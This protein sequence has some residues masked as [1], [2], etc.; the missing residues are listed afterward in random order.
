MKEK[1]I[2]GVK[3]K[4]LKFIPDER[5]RL[6]EILRK[7]DLIFESFG[8][9]YVT[10]AYPNVVKAWH[11]HKKQDDFISCIK[12]MIKLVLFDQRKKSKTNG[13]I[14]EFFIGEYNPM[15]IKIPANVWHG[16]KCISNEEAIVINIPTRAY[17]KNN[18]DEFRMPYNSKKIG[19]D[20]ELKFK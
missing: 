18:P 4:E 6:I 5:G 2:E 14:N 7:D 9:V 13:I 10:T 8:Q 3:I 16:F 17:N 20:W 12:G 15:L 1:I 19:Y 11:L